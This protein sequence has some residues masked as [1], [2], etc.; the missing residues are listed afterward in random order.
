MHSATVQSVPTI[1]EIW[2][3]LINIERVEEGA[4]RQPASAT[5]GF[6]NGMAAM[7]YNNIEA[8]P[9][10]TVDSSLVRIRVKVWHSPT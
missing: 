3:E 8:R 5:V 2:P 4:L 7:R 9:R 1:T 10:R 6:G